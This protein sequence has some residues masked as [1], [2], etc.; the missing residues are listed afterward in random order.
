M[1]R[2]LGL[3]LASAA[4]LAAAC[5]KSDKT[6]VTA[7]RSTSTNAGSATSA[8][9]TF[10]A[11]IAQQLEPGGQIPTKSEGSQ[12]DSNYGTAFSRTYGSDLST[13]E[14]GKNTLTVAGPK[15]IRQLHTT[16]KDLAVA[17]ARTDIATR[18]MAAHHGMTTY[19]SLD[20]AT[21]PDGVGEYAIMVINHDRS[22][23]VIDWVQSGSS[24]EL[25]SYVPG[26]TASRLTDAAKQIS[27]DV[28]S[29]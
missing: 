29:R 6:S 11:A 19:P 24:Y 17:R 22:G 16:G 4:I 3:A 21:Y 7:S 12:G 9:E 27:A 26:V 1:R 14:H 20:V 28:A 15:L 10:T 23:G 13:C 18:N 25:H 5:S 8:C 2:T